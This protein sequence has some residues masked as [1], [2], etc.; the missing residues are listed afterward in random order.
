MIIRVF[1]DFTRGV[2]FVGTYLV[3]DILDVVF[4]RIIEQEVELLFGKA[5]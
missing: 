1:E 4:G 2:L 3:H 5:K